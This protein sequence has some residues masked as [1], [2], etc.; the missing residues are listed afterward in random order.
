MGSSYG[1]TS[2]RN[3]KTVCSFLLSQGLLY[4][5]DESLKSSKESLLLENQG[6]ISR[7]I[8]RNLCSKGNASGKTPLIK[9]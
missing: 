1:G 6:N 8:K 3:D 4:E 7:T 9:C 5:Q 2:S